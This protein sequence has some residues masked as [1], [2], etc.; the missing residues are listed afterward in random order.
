MKNVNRFRNSVAALAVAALTTTGV[1]VAS[2]TAIAQAKTC[3][4]SGTMTWGYKDS[5]LKYIQGKIAKGEIN[6]T[7][8]AT[9]TATKGPFSF[10]VNAGKSTIDN[11]TTGTLAFDGKVNFR[12]HYSKENYGGWGLDMTISDLKLKVNGNKGKLLADYTSQEFDFDTMTPGKEISADDAVLVDV[13]F[14]KAPNLT[15]GTVDLTGTTTVADG[16]HVLG[17]G[18]YDLGDDAAAVG[19]TVKTKNCAAPTTSAAPSTSAAPTTSAKP[20]TTATSSATP[21]TSAKPSETKAPEAGG[22]SENVPTFV[23]WIAGLGVV[24]AIIAGVFGFLQSSGVPL[25]FRF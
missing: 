4:E 18:Q 16:L 1:A 5:F 6:P 2:P 3:V 19:G 25:P 13:T 20:S 8:G 11:D 7:E 21:T 22:S 23:K 24:G 12:G 15:S 17:V 9:F 10:P 14:T